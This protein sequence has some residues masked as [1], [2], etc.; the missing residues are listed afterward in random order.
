MNK[1]KLLAVASV[2]FATFLATGSAVAGL[3]STPKFGH[4]FN[5]SIVNIGSTDISTVK[6][7]S[8]TYVDGRD[9]GVQAFQLTSAGATG[10][11]QGYNIGTSTWTVGMI[12]KVPD[13][14]DSRI[15]LCAWG[16]GNGNGD[17]YG[18]YVKG[19][20]VSFNHNVGESHTEVVS[21]TVDDIT[22]FHTYVLTSNNGSLTL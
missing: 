22:D 3:G 15:C 16:P 11:T 1:L 5:G 20:V 18:L 6:N 8:G 19:N 14:G 10:N 2:A 13:L 21:A 9:E 12:A 17:M 4:T 7:I